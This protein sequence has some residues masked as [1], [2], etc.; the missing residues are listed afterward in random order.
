[1]ELTLN[2]SI[3]VEGEYQKA[4][5][6]MGR[7]TLRVFRLTTLGIVTAKGGLTQAR[8]LFNHR[9]ARFAQRLYA[10]R[11]GGQGS[12][13]IFI[14]EGVALP[15]R[16]RAAASL[17]PGDTVEQGAEQPTSLPWKGSDG[18]QDEGPPDGSGVKA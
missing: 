11:R 3:G 13:E 6:R 1:M 10:R 16:L 8:A 7:A 4:I 9:Q 17:R 12:E 15:T 18:R 14:R 2:E 5:N